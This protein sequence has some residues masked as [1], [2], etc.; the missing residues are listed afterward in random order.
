MV[1]IGT[2][3][4]T[5]TGQA[6]DVDPDEAATVVTVAS[7]VRAHLSSPT[8]IDVAVGGDKEVVDMVAYLPAGTTVEPSDRL[9]DDTTGIT[10]SIVWTRARHGL[11]L[12]HVACGVRGVRGGANG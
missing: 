5:I 1:V 4:V 9:V 6:A 12:A 10:Y 7:G 11:G 2:T 8:G 3:T